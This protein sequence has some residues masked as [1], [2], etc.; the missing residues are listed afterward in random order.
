MIREAETAK[1]QLLEMPGRKNSLMG[2]DFKCKQDFVHIVMVDESFMLVAAHIDD[3]LKGKIENGNYVDFTRLLPRDR[4]MDEQNQRL[5]WVQDRSG[6]GMFLQPATDKGNSGGIT[7]FGKWE[8]AFRVF[9]DIYCRAHPDRGAELI[10]YNH[11][12]GLAAMAYTWENVYTYDCHFRS[13][14]S[15]NPNRSWA[16]ILQQAWTMYL[17][18]RTRNQFGGRSDKKLKRDICYRFN[19]GR[20]TYGSNCK[21]DH[22]CG[23]CSRYGHGTH[24][25]RKLNGGDRRES[26][27]DRSDREDKGRRFKSKSPQRK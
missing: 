17:N 1:I 21:F 26:L 16:I 5:E 7:S 24:N 2:T 3:N 14:M 15:N 20:C 27:G 23:V 19:K 10:Q 13:H 25:C 18:D 4:I 8:Q 12:I 11:I 22:R 6:G 9:S